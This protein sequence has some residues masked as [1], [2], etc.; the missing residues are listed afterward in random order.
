MC[1]RQDAAKRAEAKLHDAQAAAEQ[2]STELTR[3]RAEVLQLR[4]ELDETT[5]QMLLLGR[6]HSAA[7]HGSAARSADELSSELQESLAARLATAQVLKREAEDRAAEL[8]RKL[9]TAQGRLAE[10]QQQAD[11]SEASMGSQLYQAQAQLVRAKADLVRSQAAAAVAAVTNAHGSS[12]AG[13]GGGGRVAGAP[14][15]HRQHEQQQQQQSGSMQT[16]PGGLDRQ[17][18]VAAQLEAAENLVRSMRATA[19]AALSSDATVC[20][21]ASA[22]G[23]ATVGATV[24]AA[25]ADAAASSYNSYH[26][27]Q[28]HQQG[29]EP[30]EVTSPF[31]AWS[32]VPV[33]LSQHLQQQQQQ[34]GG[35]GQI[36]SADGD[37]RSGSGGDGSSGGAKPS[38]SPAGWLY[39]KLF[40]SS[41][42]QSANV[43]RSGAGGVQEGAPAGA[44]FKAVPGG[45]G[46]AVS[47]EAPCLY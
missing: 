41:K 15:A 10:L 2:R 45:V 39:N 32:G 21:T 38:G 22:S 40:A 7:Q 30:G 33:S 12:S 44:D 43:S 13:G 5:Q 26:W 28:P 18:S 20:Q 37:R 6:A 19:A 29:G 1:Y 27:G 35:G 46:G 42:D 14:S 36:A 23:G 24:S 9:A 25:A 3:A 31:K 17:R 8:S 11:D 47:G 4:Q 34:M 16:M